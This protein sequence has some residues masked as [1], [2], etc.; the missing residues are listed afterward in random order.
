M[1]ICLGFLPWSC[2]AYVGSIVIGDTEC[3]VCVGKVVGSGVFGAEEGISKYSH[4]CTQW[5]KK[6]KHVKRKSGII[7]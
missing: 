6:K 3:G 4:T 5:K 1:K 7:L 2:I